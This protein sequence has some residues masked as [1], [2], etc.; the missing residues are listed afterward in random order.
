MHFLF[1][2]PDQRNNIYRCTLVNSTYLDLPA[3][4]NY[5]EKAV[6]NLLFLAVTITLVVALADKVILANFNSKESSLVHVYLKSQL[7][8]S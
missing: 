1:A 7:V 8:W 5:F 4:L 2:R 3:S 6:E